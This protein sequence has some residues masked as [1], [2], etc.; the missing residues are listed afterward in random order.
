MKIYKSRLVPTR[1]YTSGGLVPPVGSYLHIFLIVGWCQLLG[2]NI[3][4]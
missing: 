4:V 2:V 1:I 3:F